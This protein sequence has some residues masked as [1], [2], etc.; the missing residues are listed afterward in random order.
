M[1]VVV[2]TNGINAV[3]TTKIGPADSK[4]VNFDVGAIIK[5]EMKFRTVYKN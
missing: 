3:I 5:D 4:M 1:N 2:V